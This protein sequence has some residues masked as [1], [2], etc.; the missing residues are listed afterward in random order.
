MEMLFGAGDLLY[1][2]VESQGS[3]RVVQGVVVL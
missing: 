2:M 3:C 1:L